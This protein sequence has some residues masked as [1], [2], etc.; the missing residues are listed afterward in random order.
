MASLK[1]GPVDI[2][3]GIDRAYM[4]TRE[5]KKFGTASPLGWFLFGARPGTQQTSRVFHV[6]YT[7]PIDL[8]DFWTSEKMGVSP[9]SNEMSK[10]TKVELIGKRSEIANPWKVDPKPFLQPRIGCEKWLHLK[11]K[12]HPYESYLT[13]QR[14]IRD[15]V[16]MIVE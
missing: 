16:L 8:T 2:L 13:P 10:L 4:H 6:Q 14:N 12:V 1:C 15:G 9:P 3:I 7:K 11:G 5:S